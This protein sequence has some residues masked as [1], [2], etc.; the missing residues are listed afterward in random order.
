MT[1]AADLERYIRGL[2]ISQGRYAGAPF[3]LHNWQRRFLKGAFKPGVM[4][5]ALTLARGGGKTTFT[6]ALGAATVDVD[7]PLVEPRAE[8]VIVA[9]SFEQAMIAFRHT[10]AFMQPTFERWGVGK[11]GR[12]RVQDSVNRASITDTDTGAMLRCI[13]SDPARAHGL[14]RPPW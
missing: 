2:T 5:A 14:W 11:G 3:D 1:L 10:L 9:S 7:G 8:S 4:D 12:Y 13:G 6:A